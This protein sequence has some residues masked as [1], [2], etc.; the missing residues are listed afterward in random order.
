MR[1]HGIAGSQAQKQETVDPE[2]VKWCFETADRIVG[3][4]RNPFLKSLRDQTERGR[5]LSQKQFAILVK[6]VGE[7]AAGLEDCD[8]IRAKLSEYV[9][10][11]F[12]PIQREGESVVPRLIALIGKVTEWRPSSKKGRKTYDDKAF[13]QSLVDQYER[14]RSLSPRQVMALRRVIVAYKDKIPGYAEVAGPLGLDDIP[15]SR[16]KKA[17]VIDGPGD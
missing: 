3:L 16:D 17:K 14:R 8:A 11:G 1:E 2:L 7:N 5:G 10:G 4:M 15:S 12:S 9:S 6:S 13:V